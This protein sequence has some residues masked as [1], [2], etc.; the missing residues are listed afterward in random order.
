MPLQIKL[1]IVK[2]EGGPAAEE[3]DPSK[4]PRMVKSLANLDLQDADE[5]TQLYKMDVES[6][7]KY[8]RKANWEDLNRYTGIEITPDLLRD[9][10]VNYQKRCF[11]EGA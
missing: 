10:I 11:P 4:D 1:S 3:Q 5:D 2:N 8:T 9:W 6:S 7:G